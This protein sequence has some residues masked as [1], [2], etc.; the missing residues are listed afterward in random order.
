VGVDERIA[1]ISY[2]H[3]DD[4]AIERLEH[5]TRLLGWDPWCDRELTGGQRWWDGILDNIRRCDAFIFALSASSNRSEACQSELAYASALGKPIV[6]VLVGE[7]VAEG[8]LPPLL[9]EMHYI[10]HRSDSRDSVAVYARAL[11]RLS[12]APPLP[13]PL[14]PAP[15]VPVSYLA[16]LRGRVERP[17]LSHEEQ[18]R[19]LAELQESLTRPEQA[20]VAHVLL[21]DF[22]KRPDLMQSVATS[23]NRALAAYEDA[24]PSTPAPLPPPPPPGDPVAPGGA[25]GARKR[26]VAKWAAVG[27][28]VVLLIGGGLA[29][30][31]LVRDDR[32]GAEGFCESAARVDETVERAAIALTTPEV[33]SDEIERAFTTGQQEMARFAES[34]PPAVAEAVADYRDAF[35][36]QVALLEEGGWALAGAPDEYFQGLFDQD[37]VATEQRVDRYVSEECD[38]QLLEFG[39]FIEPSTAARNLAVVWNAAALRLPVTTTQADCFSDRIVAEVDGDRVLALFARSDVQPTSAETDLLVS[40]TEQCIDPTAIGEYLGRL[41][42]SGNRAINDDE[43][44]CLGKGIVEQFTLSGWV[45]IPPGGPASPDALADLEEISQSC[46]VDPREV[47][48]LIGG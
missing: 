33:S 6:P 12:P 31:L 26:S 9:A 47:L 46:G 21:Q 17:T 30:Y 8:L 45:D 4:A 19:L 48:P 43:A 27:G 34:A 13:E 3:V 44:A 36:R 37:A 22:A 28:A 2:S 18:W 16:D 10:D 24:A 42:F 32:G 20:D 1:F 15:A 14:P 5:D 39:R 23:A 38:V 7:P 40:A 41:T 11:S 29:T 35:D 25:G